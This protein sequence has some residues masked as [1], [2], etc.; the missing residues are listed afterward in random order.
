MDRELVLQSPLE[1]QLEK[2]VLR[3]VARHVFDAA[4]F[5]AMHESFFFS[6]IG[7]PRDTQDLC[8]TLRNWRNS[9]YKQ[10]DS[11]GVPSDS[12]DRGVMCVLT[13]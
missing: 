12:L 2:G 1:K 11:T 6:E 8:A 4:V 7:R 13:H 9:G 3:Q 10:L 5:V